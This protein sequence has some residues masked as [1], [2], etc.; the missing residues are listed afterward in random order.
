M[1]IKKE[2][3]WVDSSGF[4]EID[5]EHPCPPA[6]SR[7]RAARARRVVWY[8]VWQLTPPIAALG[9]VAASAWVVFG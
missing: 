5:T 8:W 6:A 7:L 2:E 1:R 4:A 3:G 9:L